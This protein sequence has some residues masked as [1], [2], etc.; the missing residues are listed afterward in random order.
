MRFVVVFIYF[1]PPAETLL[2]LPR[3]STV[4]SRRPMPVNGALVCHGNLTDKEFVFFLV[5]G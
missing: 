4:P 2:P 5:G 1:F 3:S